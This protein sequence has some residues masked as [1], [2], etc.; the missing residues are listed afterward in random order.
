M[1]TTG[2]P[3]TH[4][5]SPGFYYSQRAMDHD[6]TLWA[7]GPVDAFYRDLPDPQIPALAPSTPGIPQIDQRDHSLC[8]ISLD[9]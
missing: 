9:R 8:S 4:M 5:L 2:R 6:L 3:S 7:V 1:G